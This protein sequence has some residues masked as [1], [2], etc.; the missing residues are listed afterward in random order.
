[1]R[2]AVIVCLALW[3]T[4]TANG[5]S[6][7]VVAVPRWRVA[8]EGRGVPAVCGSLV[9]FLT[10]RH[11]VVALDAATGDARWRRTTG[12]PGEET[13]GS[14][15]LVSGSVVLAGDYAILAF[16]SESG[17]PKWRFDPLDGYGAGLYLGKAQDGVAFAGSPS[18]RLYAIGVVD[19]RP[20]WSVT[21]FADVSPAGPNVTIFQPV[22]SG[23][24]VV[25]GYSRFG[26][27]TTGGVMVVDRVSG[28]ERWRSEFPPVSSD[29]ITGFGGGPV[30]AADLVVAA[31]GDGRIYAFDRATGQTRWAAPP[32]VRADGRLQERDWR[33]LAASGSRLIAGSVSGVLTTIDVRDGKEKWRYSHP[34]GGSIGLQIAADDESAYVPHLGGLLVAIGLRDGRVRWQIGG[35]S[36]GFNWAP[37]VVGGSVYAAASRSGLFAVPR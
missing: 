3:L 8:G 29:R 33:A 37:A 32:V 27:P 20:I 14:S 2:R 26:R 34:D 9:Y 5:P 10:K 30:V 23:D 15:V 7:N 1:M 24:V 17:T 11:E 6:G 4:A 28:R 36:D 31:S 16:D 18:G 21:P 13:L 12:E 19:G 35:F 22:V 25:S